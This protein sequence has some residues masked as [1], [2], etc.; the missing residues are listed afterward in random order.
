MQ[1]NDRADGN[2]LYI[3]V[4]IKHGGKDICDEID[5]LWSNESVSK[6]DFGKE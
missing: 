5:T 4:L 2:Q 1:V 6:R 3:L